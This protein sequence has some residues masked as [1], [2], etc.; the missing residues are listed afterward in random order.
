MGRIYIDRYTGTIRQV[1]LYL[2]D[3]TLK[4]GTVIHGLEPRR[5]FPVTNAE[6]FITLVD[7]EEHEIAF[8]RDLEEVDDASAEALRACFRESY[9]VPRIVRLEHFEEA[10]GVYTFHA[11]TDLGPVR[12]RVAN[13]IHHIK[14]IGN[15]VILQDT[16]DNRYEIA[17][18]QALDP[19]SKRLLFSFL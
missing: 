17:D 6:M 8:V 14:R 2:V 5:L 7:E 19:H 11:G 13:R 9:R 3:V 12:F 1:D 15:R 10:G 4:D 18:W 16:N